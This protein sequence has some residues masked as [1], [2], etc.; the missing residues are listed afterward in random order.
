MG[1]VCQSTGVGEVRCFGTPFAI[2]RFLNGMFR[3]AVT[4]STL[5][6]L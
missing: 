1:T 3:T 6:L 5:V 4:C 2:V